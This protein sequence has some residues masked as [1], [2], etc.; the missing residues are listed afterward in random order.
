MADA[1]AQSAIDRPQ[2]AAYELVL[3]GESYR[4]RQKPGHHSDDPPPA[5]RR[6]RD[7]MPM[8]KLR[9]PGPGPM[10]LAD[11]WSHAPG[12]RHVVDTTPCATRQL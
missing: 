12:G 6:R 3:D 1:L 11:R 10:S 4:R 5:A 9:S 2:S 8:P 7:I